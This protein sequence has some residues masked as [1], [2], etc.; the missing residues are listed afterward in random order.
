[1]S[2][3]EH[4]AKDLV[5]AHLGVVGRHQRCE[6]VLAIIGIAASR[7][8]PWFSSES[9]RFFEVLV[10]VKRSRP[11]ASAAAPSH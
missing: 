6:P 9:W 5:T 10:F 3:A 8:M 1:M 2:E 7:L 4:R 11:L